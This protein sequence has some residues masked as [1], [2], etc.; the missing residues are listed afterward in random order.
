MATPLQR[1]VQVTNNI[2]TSGQNRIDSLLQ[3][4]KWGDVLGTGVLDL[5]YSFIQTIALLR[6]N[7]AVDQ[8]RPSMVTGTQFIQDF[9]PLEPAQQAAADAAIQA[10]ADVSNITFTRLT[11]PDQLVGELEDQRVGDIRF[12]LSRH[13]NGKSTATSQFPDSPEAGDIWFSI[14][15][16]IDTVDS[17]T[18]FITRVTGNPIYRNS[19]DTDRNLTSKGTYD[20][21]TFIHEI[22]HALGLKHPHDGDIVDNN[23]LQEYSVMSYRSFTGSSLTGYSQNFFPTTP[24]LNDIEA[25][26]YLY[27]VNT[28]TR[29]GNSVYNWN[30]FTENGRYSQFLQTIWDAGGIDEISWADAPGFLFHRPVKINLNS[31]EWSEIGLPYSTNGNAITVKR[32]VAIARE[33]IV[34]EQ[35]INRIENATGGSGDDELIGNVVA[36]ILNGGLG[37]DT[38]RGGQGDDTYYVDNIGDSITEVANEGTVDLVYSSLFSYALTDNVE[39]L[40]LTS[41]ANTGIGNGIANVITGNEQNNLL[42]GKEGSDTLYGGAG[43][44]TLIGG[45]G[46]IRWMGMRVRIPLPM[47]PLLVESR[48]ALLQVRGQEV[49]PRAIALYPLKTWKAL[50]TRIG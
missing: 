49:M 23:M 33:A 4:T 17:T 12:A 5:E 39:N 34:N 10:W 38:M 47:L 18:G 25:I 26:Q 46:R 35:V 40:T 45:L 37:S 36:N 41:S 30:Y 2:A 29:S 19:V 8:F 14:D 48:L 11:E 31:G 32:T 7:Y 42:D 50:V 9:Q 20:Y 6:P 27:G 16:G 3:R 22:G 43:N 24:M 13:V 15:N 44:D 1:N 28:T 21:Q